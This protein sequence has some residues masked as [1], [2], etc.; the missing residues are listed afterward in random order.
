MRVRIRGAILCPVAVALAIAG[1]A[2][3]PKQAFDPQLAKT[4]NTTASEAAVT[5]P[6]TKVCRWV[7]L[8]IAERDWIRGVV[9]QSQGSNIRVRIEDAGRFPNTLNGHRLGRGETISD[10]AAA[11][12]PCTF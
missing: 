11:W 7:Q 9:Q 6:G 10:A 4:V 8:G 1:C 5:K 3:E 2:T 12:T